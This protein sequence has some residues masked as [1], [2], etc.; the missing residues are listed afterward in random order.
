MDPL[1]I[2]DGHV[3]TSLPTQSFCGG[4]DEGDGDHLGQVLGVLVAVIAVVR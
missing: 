2:S 1:R 4:L 3:P